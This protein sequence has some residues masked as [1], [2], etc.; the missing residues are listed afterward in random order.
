MFFLSVFYNWL[1]GNTDGHSKNYGLLLDGSRPRLA[2][3]YD[4]NSL[5]PYMNPGVE[6][7]RPA[8]RFR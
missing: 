3:L 1:I 2:P 8:M 5:A 6:L 7:S 4:L